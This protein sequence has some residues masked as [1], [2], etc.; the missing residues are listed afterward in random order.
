MTI[1]ERIRQDVELLYTSTNKF[2]EE[3]GIS[4]NTMMKIYTNGIGCVSIR[5]IQRLAEALGYNYIELMNGKI[6]IDQNLRDKINLPATPL[7]NHIEEDLMNQFRNLSIKGQM[8]VIEYI[9]D[10]KDNYRKE[11]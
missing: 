5:V 8:K 6:V 10:I 7:Y 4:R 1:N 9:E 2:S 11:E 3:V